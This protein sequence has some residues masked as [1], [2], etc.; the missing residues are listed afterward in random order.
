M[1]NDPRQLQFHHIR[2]ASVDPYAG[3]G[4]LSMSHAEAAELIGRP[5]LEIVPEPENDETLADVA[6]R[7][8]WSRAY[9]GV[10]EALD[11]LNRHF[12]NGSH[13]RFGLLQDAARAAAEASGRP[14]V[15]GRETARQDL[16]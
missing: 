4:G 3:A 9:D 10:L 16:A 12:P 14:L 11:V 2:P 15:Q 8:A 13:P 6:W 7:Q 1:P 5:H